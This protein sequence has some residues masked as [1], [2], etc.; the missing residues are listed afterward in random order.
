MLPVGGYQKPEI[1][2]FA[3]EAGLRVAQKKDSYE[4]CFV[5]NDDYAGFLKNYRGHAD[6]EGDFVDT[7]GNVLG[8]HA[9]Y[10][11]FTVGQRKGLGITFGEPRF[12]ISV[13]AER[14]QVVLG[15]REDLATSAIRA[16]DLNWLVDRPASS[17]EC[18]VKV[19]YQQQSRDC[20]VEL[21]NDN[22]ALITPAEPIIGVAPGQAAVFYDGDRVLGG[23]WIQ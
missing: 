2:A 6:T 7:E 19:R 3:E 16:V 12:V 23:G 18:S 4:I 22:E 17:F 8:Q 15:Q 20:T 14:R 10:E 11:K 5:P 21:L 9:G 1:R 13:N